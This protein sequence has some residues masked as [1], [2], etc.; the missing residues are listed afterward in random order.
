MAK[1]ALAAVLG[2][3]LMLA[4][5]SGTRADDPDQPDPRAEAEELAREAM[6]RMLK[7]LELLVQSIPQYEM[8][9]VTEDGDIIIRRKRPERREAPPPRESAPEP[10]FDNT[11]T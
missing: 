3:S 10:E 4:V 2:L 6:E 8:P 1:R 5:P 11:S 7:A 9:E